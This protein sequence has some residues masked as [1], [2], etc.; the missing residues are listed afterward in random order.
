[1]KYNIIF[2]CKLGLLYLAHCTLHKLGE[3]HVHLIT[4]TVTISVILSI[5]AHATQCIMRVMWDISGCCYSKPLMVPG[6]RVFVWPTIQKIQR[7]AYHM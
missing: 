2:Y 3:L 5:S 1:M 4:A 7:Y 6:G